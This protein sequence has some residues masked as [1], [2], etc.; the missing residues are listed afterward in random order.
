MKDGRTHLAHKAEHAVDFDSGAVVAVTI[1]PADRGDTDS[2]VDT[3]LT[4]LDELDVVQP[5]GDDDREIVA[6]KGYHST[7]RV[8]RLGRHRPAHLH[9]GTQPRA[10]ALARPNS[11]ARRR[12]SQSSTHS[13][14]AWPA[15]VATARRVP[16]AARLPTRMKP[17]RCD[18]RICVATE[19]LEARPD[20]C[21][22]LQ[23]RAHHA[24]PDRRGHPARPTGPGGG[25]VGDAMGGPGP[26]ATS[27]GGHSRV[28]RPPQRRTRGPH[29]VAVAHKKRD[30]LHGLLV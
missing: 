20:S 17:A 2:G 27:R 9:L 12:L 6:D 8:T 5:D 16:G 4:A 19:H 30:L 23:S 15:A 14:G 25:A 1:Q 13:R 24:T 22:W 3:V 7:E 21:G 29:G 28:H 11:L 10:T 26:D 18:A